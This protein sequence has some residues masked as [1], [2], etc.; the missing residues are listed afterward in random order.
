MSRF[1]CVLLTAV[2]LAISIPAC[3]SANGG[4]VVSTASGRVRGA[5]VGPVAVFQGIPFAAP[6]VGPL[7][8]REPQPPQRWKGL[9]DATKPASGCFQ[10]QYGTDTFITSLAAVY[11]V[12]FQTLAVTSSEDCLYLNVWTPNLA[13]T[14]KLPVMVWLHG[15]SNRV[16]SGA[17]SF[18]DGTPLV[19]HGVILVTVNYRLGV[20]G[21]FSH[22]EL[23]QESP[24]HASGNYGLLDQLQALR[25]VQQN[26]AQ[27]GGDPTN[28]T[29]FGESAGSIDAGTLMASPLSYRLFQRVILE[30][31]PPLGLGLPMT[32]AR[33]EQVGAAVAQAAPGGSSATL[34]PLRS[35]PPALVTELARRVVQEHFKGFDASSPVVDGWLLP[36]AP[37]EIFASGKAQPVELMIGFNGRELSAFRIAGA[38]AAKKT[39]KQ[40][41]TA[42]GDAIKS[43]AATAHPLYGNWTDI[44]IAVNAGRILVHHDAAIDQAS[45]DMLVACPVG[46]LASLTNNAGHHAYIYRFD[47][48][49]PGRGESDLGAFHSLELAYVFSSFGDRA[50]NWLP[51]TEADHKLSNVIQTY[52]TNF[53]KTGDPNSPGLPHWSSWTNENEPFLLFDRK[54]EVQP[55]HDFS[56]P[57]CH[58]DPER[59][60]RQLA[61]Q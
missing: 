12:A 2:Y 24:H 36:K 32:L 45:N 34:G 25:W 26:I 39:G 60:K 3:G 28:V 20:M 40:E 43:L 38:N 21:F 54:A 55:Q 56:P 23:T 52:W 59:L 7:R 48:S 6:P 10:D 58:L 15:G 41:K 22:P 18:Y 4:P 42:A 31:G 9:R 29:L 57:F 33:A 37:A 61:A 53:A 27:F 47:R 35:L 46:A 50:W 17:Q 14:A 19:S 8:W 30:S 16:G 51:F 49:I 13:A 11:G 5:Q 44:A 1:C